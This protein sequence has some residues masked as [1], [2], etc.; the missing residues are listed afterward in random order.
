MNWTKLISDLLAADMTQAEIAKRI[1]VTQSAISQVLH[2]KT[3]QGFRFEPGRKLVAL[4]RKVMAKQSKV[5]RAA[6][7]D[8]V[9]PLGGSSDKTKETKQVL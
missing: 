1:G 2:Q 7:S 3:Q 6:A 9:Q 4:H 5:D 8:D